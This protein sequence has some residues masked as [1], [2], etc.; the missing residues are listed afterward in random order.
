MIQRLRTVIMRTGRPLP[1]KLASTL[2]F[3]RSSLLLVALL[4]VNPNA[5]SLVGLS[6]AISSPWRWIVF[7]AASAVAVTMLAREFAEKFHRAAVRRASQRRLGPLQ[8]LQF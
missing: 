6:D 7:W 2:A 3:V 4:T 5:L 1:Q 8:R